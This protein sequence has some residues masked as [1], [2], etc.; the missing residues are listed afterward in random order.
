MVD[1]L[2]SGGLE[3]QLRA[4]LRMSVLIGPSGDGACA[5][6]EQGPQTAVTVFSDA[7]QLDLSTSAVLSRHQ[8]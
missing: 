6:G 1:R 5:V 7:M 2:P 3:L 8:R 4:T